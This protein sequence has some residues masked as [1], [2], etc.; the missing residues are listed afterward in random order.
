MVTTKRRSPAP[1][2]E[3]DTAAE[4]LAL[5]SDHVTLDEFFARHPVKLTR[6]DYE[7]MFAVERRE[8]ARFMVADEDRRQRR[9]GN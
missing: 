4:L 9:K 2:P 6:E 3:A 5:A 7:K 8:R 1:Q